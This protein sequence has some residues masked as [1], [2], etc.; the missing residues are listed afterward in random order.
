MDYKKLSDD[1]LYGCQQNCADC[2]YAGDH[3]FECTITKLAS[4]AIANLLIENQALRNAANGFKER[5]EAAEY[6]SEQKDIY[7]D[8]MIDAFAAMDSADLEATKTQLKIAEARAEAIEQ[9][10]DRLLE[11]MKPNCLM[12]DS[13]HKNGNCIEVGGFCTAV[14]AAY[15]PLIPKFRA[16]AEAAESRAEKAE[17][18][19]DAAIEEI[20]KICYYCKHRKGWK[21]CEDWNGS[22]EAETCEKWEWRGQKEE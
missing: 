21:V 12:C 13:M 17:R 4:S 7:Y 19:R 11:A 15:C 8:Q 5:A 14:P 9:D 2:V 18:E 1:L 6:E 22:Q 10:R 3:E 16:R 20:P